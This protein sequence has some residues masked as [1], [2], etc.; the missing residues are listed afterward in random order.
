MWGIRA[1]TGG[2]TLELQ[3]KALTSIKALSRFYLIVAVE[4]GCH[5]WL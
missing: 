2:G 3:A 4:L 5:G 1:A